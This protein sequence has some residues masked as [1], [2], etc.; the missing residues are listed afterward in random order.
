MIRVGYSANVASELLSDF[1]A[2]IELIALP[3]DLDHDVEIEVWIPD[4]YPTRNRYIVPHLKG[5]KLVLSMMAGTEWI[6]A[7]MGPHVTI[8]N[9]RGA[10]NI[11]TS[12]WTLS[13]ILTMLKHFPLFLDI[14]RS[15]EWKRRF[16]ATAEYEN[17]TGDTRALYPPVMLEE[18]TAKTVM[19]VGYGSIGKEI[20]RMLEPFRV[21]LIRVARTARERPPVH[22]VSELDALLPKA[23]IVILILP[24]TNESKHLIDAHQF[25]LMQKGALLVNAARGPI[26]NTD[27]LVQ[28]L[29]S[30]R[31]RAAI[32]VTDPEPLPDGH[33]LWRCPNL[34]IT[35]H[36]GG[37]SPEFAR[38]SLK[39]AADELR[40]YM[41]GEPLLNVVQ[42]AV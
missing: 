11:S 3:R 22:S 24:A 20:E 12:E 13:A 8:C 21:N 32:D 33:P 42:A 25:S 38:R 6:P 15:G 40:R 37:S 7:A 16:Q 4:P 31:I 28:A 10:H 18:L 17:L 36:V 5:V 19:L 9:A 29:E 26:V 41:A 34:L 27:A 30:R 14:Q 35:P 23:Q 39:I 2:G 1:P